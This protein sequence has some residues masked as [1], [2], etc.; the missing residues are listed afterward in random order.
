M[1]KR[2]YGAT[3]DEVTA[4]KAI[5]TKSIIWE[6]SRKLA[7]AHKTYWDARLEDKPAAEKALDAYWDEFERLHRLKAILRIQQA[8]DELIQ[9]QRAYRDAAPEDKEAA[10][11][12]L[13][14]CREDLEA[15]MGRY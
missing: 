5:R 14:A 1:S 10:E 8:S 4:A 15:L 2:Y 7:Q 11:D 13:E 9:A 6:A 12:E 3:A